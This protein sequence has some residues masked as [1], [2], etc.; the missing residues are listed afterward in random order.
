MSNNV[1][2]FN[3]LSLRN[4]KAFILCNRHG[5]G[6]KNDLAIIVNLL[7]ASG[8]DAEIGE[9]ES[10]QGRKTAKA[11]V[12]SGKYAL[13]IPFGGDGTVNKAATAIVKESG[14]AL[15][16]IAGGTF[17][18]FSN[19]LYA[20]TDS[21]KPWLNVLRMMEASVQTI[22]IG[23]MEPYALHLQDGN[24]TVLELDKDLRHKA[25]FLLSAS[26]GAQ[27]RLLKYVPKQ[28]KYRADSLISGL[29]RLVIYGSGLLHIGSFKLFS[30]TVID[31]DNFTAWAGK[32]RV[33]M[34]A[35]ANYAWQKPVQPIYLDDNLLT[36]VAIKSFWSYAIG[37]ASSLVFKAKSL[38]FT[39][40]SNVP[41]ELDGSIV[42]FVK[43][44]D[45]VGKIQSI[46]YKCGTKTVKVLVPYCLNQ[47]YISKMYEPAPVQSQPNLPVVDPRH[48]FVPGDKVFQVEVIGKA[49]LDRG[50]YIIYGQDL[51]TQRPI[52]IRIQSDCAMARGGSAAP[53]NLGT[54]KDGAVISVAGDNTSWGILAHKALL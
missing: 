11:A 25:Y 27:A 12:Q 47:P 35:K 20:N 3:D 39:L 16:P 23:F 42:D 40:P 41:V 19:M 45:G 51:T 4:A 24:Q 21:H 14:M 43:K 31:Q 17:N 26:A 37:K 8:I 36:G 2:T 32:A 7:K 28:L 22:N 38:L 54:I 5:G 6:K 1:Q 53:L 34:I 18:H 15:A 13:I 49:S 52:V 30:T 9:F 29:G 44:L 33:A 46:T 48:F 10:G 50:W